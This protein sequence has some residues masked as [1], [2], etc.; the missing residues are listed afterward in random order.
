MKIEIRTRELKNGNRTIYLDYYDKGRRW[1]E[2][3]KLYLVPDTAPY[4]RELNRNAMDRA[5][6][7]RA[8]RLLGGTAEEKGKQ[9]EEKTDKILVSAWIDEYAK[10]LHANAGLSPAYLKHFDTLIRMVNGYLAHIKSPRLTMD[11]IGRDF[12]RGFLRYMTDVHK[13]R[14]PDGKTRRLVQS[15]LHLFQ[16]KMNTM[17]NQAA[18]DGVIKCNP[19]HLLSREERIKKPSGRRDFMTREELYRL[20]EV[21]TQSRTTKTAFV[22]CC[23][24]GL[25]Y[26]DVKQLKWRNIEKTQSG[27]VVRI[28][29]MEKTEKPVIV[30][31]GANAMA[32]LPEC[33]DK[34]PD[35]FVF[36]MGSC[37]GCNAALKT[38]ARRAGINKRVSFHTSRHTFATL[39]LAAT[40]DIATVSG[41]L[42]HTSVATTQIYAEV[43]MED[44][45]AAV[46]KLHDIFKSEN[47]ALL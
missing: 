46:N 41:L 5:V 16:L 31:L 4:A 7:I 22:F 34:T 21:K 47:T 33:G 39:T 43:L 35:D 36:D 11:C 27:T 25:R 8:K 45:I 40:K 2:Y 10:T 38:M 15:T 20:M 29:A 9:S 37:G 6:A 13:C 19:Y 30:P 44:K 14:T 18:R 1:Y 32:W 23:F 24:T 3:P 28:E 12:Y 17:L 26:S 42:G